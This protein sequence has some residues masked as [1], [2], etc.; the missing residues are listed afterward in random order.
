MVFTSVPKA[1]TTL[2]STTISITLLTEILKTEPEIRSSICIQLLLFRNNQNNVCNHSFL[3]TLEFLE[4]LCRNNIK[5]NQEELWIFFPKTPTLYQWT[6]GIS[7][8]GLNS[9]EYFL[10]MFFN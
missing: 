8:P 7:S 5:R 6:T 9:S 3:V 2:F 1:T 10:L 4:L